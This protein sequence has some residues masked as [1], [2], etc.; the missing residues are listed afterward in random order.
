[1]VRAP[2]CHA[3]GRGFESRRSRRTEKLRNRGAFLPLLAIAAVFTGLAGVIAVCVTLAVI[4][5][6]TAR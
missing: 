2:A 3:G 1:M 6:V 5:I 4:A